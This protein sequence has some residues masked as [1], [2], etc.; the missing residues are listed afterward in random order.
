MTMLTDFL[1]AL[2]AKGTE[3][4]IDDGMLGVRAAQGVLSPADLATL[5]AHKPEL[6]RLL[7]EHTIE[8]PLSVG[9]EGLWFIQNS[10]PDS[11]GYNLA[12]AL[13]IESA[14]DPVPALRR[15]VQKLV[16]RHALLRTTFPVVDGTP[17]QVVRAYRA[18]DLPIV[19]AAGWSDA[20]LMAAATQL[21]V[22]PF[23]LE[24]EGAFRAGLFRRSAGE[25]LLV[26]C[27]HHI[28]VDAW[29][30]RMLAAELLTLLG[31]DGSKA[32]P[33]PPVKRTYQQFVA[34]Q[35]AMLAQRGEALGRAWQREL[36]DMPLVLDLPTDRPRPPVQTFRGARL[37]RTLPPALSD[38]LR[39]LARAQKATLYTVFLAAYQVLLHRYT[40]QEDFCVGS[41]A[42]LREREELSEIFG[43]LVN[44]IVQRTRISASSPPTF[45]ELLRDTR[46]RALRV[47]DLQEYPF[48]L[49]AKAMLKERDPSR[50][51]IAQVMF[52]YQRA[53]RFSGPMTELL[54]GA[55]AAAGTA[56]LTLVPL[57]QEISEAELLLEVT[58]HETRH[59]LSFRYNT[60]VL[61]AAT[62]ARI[63]GQ[64]ETLLADIVADPGRKVCDLALLTPEAQHKLLV[65]WNR[66]EAPFSSD[67]CIHHLFEA[68]ADLH[69]DAP[70][71][72]DLCDPVR[73]GQAITYREL[74][75]RANRVAHRLLALGVGQETFVGVCLP[76][77]A[78]LIVAL[79]GVLK[80]G[81]A[82]VV[83][84][85][86]HPRK[87]LA[88]LLADTGAP[89][90]LTRGALRAVLPETSARVVDFDGGF[91]DEPAARPRGRARPESIAYVLYTSGSTGEPNGALIEHRGLVNSIEAHIRI[92]EIGPG[93]RLLHLLSFNFDAAMAHLF[94]TI[95]AGAALYLAPRDGD[96]LSGSLVETM[97]REAI[98]HLPIVPSMLAALPDTAL[99][100]LE[101]ILVG[102][103][104]CT[105]ELVNRW[106]RGR[107][108]LNVYG[109]TEATILATYTA[110]V[111][112][113]QTPSIGRPIA[114][115]Q[116]YVLDP[117]GRL[118]PPGVTGEL[119]LG[120][121]GVARGY[122]NRPELTPR[123]FIENP[124]DK[125]G[126]RLY[127]TGDLVR[128]RMNAQEPPVLD[129]VGRLDTQI[130][131][132]GYRIELSEVERALRASPRVREAVATVIEAVKG[133]ESSRR[134]VAYVT[135]ARAEDAKAGDLAAALHAELREVLPSHLVPSPIVVLP[136][137]P[138]TV[139]GKV[140]MRALPHPGA[141]AG[142]PTAAAPP[143][144][145]IER[146]I[147]AAWCSVLGVRQ[148]NIHES[149]FELGGHSLLA[150]TLMS[151]L[152]AEFGRK[153][154]VKAL[155]Q[156]PT[157]E[158]LARRVSGPEEAQQAPFLIPM[159]TRGEGPPIFVV[160]ALGMNGVYLHT[161]GKKL[162]GDQPT[163]LIDLNEVVDGLPAD[164][165]LDLAVGRVADAVQGVRPE[166][167]CLLTGQ[168]SGV[169]FAL[170]VAVELEARGLRTAFVNLDGS[171][172]HPGRKSRGV[173]HDVITVARFQNALLSGKL[174]VDF[175]AVQKL[176]E[177]ERWPVIAQSFVRAGL[178]PADAG[179][180]ALRRMIRVHAQHESLVLDHVPPRLYTGRMVLIWAADPWDEDIADISN[181]GTLVSKE[182]WAELA[183]HPPE[184]LTVPGNHLTLILEPYVGLVAEH[185]RRV[186]SDLLTTGAAA[187]ASFPVAWDSPEEAQSMW[188]LDEVH[189]LKQMR[190]LD[191]DLRLRPMVI[192]TNRAYERYGIPLR[193]EPK[194]IHAFV[195]QKMTF[196][197]LPP[198]E[199]TSRVK[200]ADEAVRR[201]A[202]ALE[203]RWEEDWLPEVKAHLA[204]LSAFDLG[205]ASLPA[206]LAHLHQLHDRLLR[207]W[208]I[209]FELLLAAILAISD[210]EDAYR[211]L[212]PDAGPFEAYDL[213]AGFPNK[214]IEANDRLQQLGSDAARDP[215]L[216]A[217]LAKT[218]PSAL[219][220]TLARTPESHA[221]WEEIQR[222]LRA[223]GERNDDLYIDSP[224]WI[225]D[226]IPVLR[227]LREAA[228]RPE[229]DPAAEHRQKVARREARL[230]EVRALLASYP[231][232]VVD[233]FEAL[234]RA[235]QA[236][237]VLSE[238]HH[239]WIDC[240]V[241]FHAR[242]VCMEVG[243]RLARRGALQTPGDVFDLTLDEISKLSAE[244]GA[245]ETIRSVS[246][247]RRA[248]AA[249]FAGRR[250]PRSLG[251][252]RP[253]PAV[254]SACL[255][256]SIKFSGGLVEPSTA[257]GELRGL[258]GSRGKVIGPAR[259][260]RSLSDAAKLQPGDILVAP[261][262]LP[263]WT[264]FFATVAAVVTDTGGVLSHAAV[265]AREYGIAAVVGAQ[266]ATESIRDGQIV[267]V[268]GDAGIVRVGA[269]A[270]GVA[271]ETAGNKAESAVV[272]L[273]EKESRQHGKSSQLISGPV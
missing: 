270:G 16:N 53:Q 191:F 233:E 235:A 119:C 256:A 229:R 82:V 203:R 168:S 139:N 106:G 120:G 41:V 117:H 51:P 76:R 27:M 126:S 93:S 174:G 25:S 44:E 64:L 68:Q 215:V 34:L 171:A 148:A 181:V 92:M 220:D 173:P 24:Q 1:N 182:G 35:N 95:C 149:F 165:T 201:T 164:A 124:F 7:P 214:T 32:N 42:G 247:S 100:A 129:F 60:D 163:Y 167:P 61:D 133:Q 20:A 178:L 135:P 2:L 232:A 112:D 23:D 267:E 264:P 52:S 262:T 199:L 169:R 54:S 50:A 238:D 152:S 17:R 47:L 207:L 228:A 28:A 134:L 269:R 72:V 36:Q 243:R 144:T 186:A 77:G 140:D 113:G 160:S 185:L 118:V 258:S 271:D 66:S 230:A 249:P 266:G 37:D 88:S 56:R 87:R 193:I 114:N 130:K 212:F 14:G 12:I 154:P 202:A 40:G 21:H 248:A 211:D 155:F 43:Y 80:A 115:M 222:Y 57:P 151:R 156:A 101:T 260:L 253:L 15:T 89:L 143:R 273:I 90:V 94:D 213:L 225:D 250:P 240:K 265:V 183:E 103:E 205:T 73:P 4:S 97:V 33:L 231:P 150:V 268:D 190:A 245:Q 219:A 172:P 22:R 49:L 11:A 111:P 206:L 263:S 210:F 217:I 242:R 153:L 31:A 78:D 209:H 127:R 70:A 122:L 254:E 226:P 158:A 177:S 9:Q 6:L 45:L 236:G 96:F 13:R 204:E 98:T 162:G 104:R 26:L 244:E 110:C 85:P 223:Y 170:A 187:Q 137:L 251:T 81:G 105:A 58:E 102:G 189:N 196:A 84:D 147:A 261:A 74:D 157:I 188:L 166:G 239:F 195:Y 69:P 252:V 63:A 18:F 257:R 132:R 216:R 272:A 108:F 59:E 145:D 246:D 208:E 99:P 234:L 48:P 146:R 198:A 83:L 116:V 91:K 259:V 175:A 184:T 107:R 19:D 86:E 200:A 131:L 5:R 10:A 141:L 121:V 67:A 8:A 29:S 75:R 197:D 192:G 109:P 255:K 79:L 123:K 224:T 227:G 30:F 194:L 180:E 62:V 65:T 71:L 159:N 55:T 176:P 38:G 218:D 39:A 46:E 161:L 142:T 237:T 179:V 221:L 241:T 128:Y 138:L 136:G 125:S 3:L